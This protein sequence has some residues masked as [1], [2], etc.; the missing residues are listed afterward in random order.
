MITTNSGTKTISDVLYV[1]DIDQN[2]LSVGQLVEK[3]FDLLFGK[4][5]CVIYDAAGEQILHVK[6]RRKSFSFDPT[7]EE[8]VAYVGDE[9]EGN[10]K[11][12]FDDCC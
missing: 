12:F 7:E 8:Q 11:R 5:H 4:R 10:D 2:L 6:M 9:E 3:G 1:P